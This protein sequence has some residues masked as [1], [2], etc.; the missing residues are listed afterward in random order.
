MQYLAKF[1]KN[2]ATIFQSQQN[3]KNIFDIFAIFCT[4][5][6]PESLQNLYDWAL[7]RH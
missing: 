2:V 6:V 4:M 5:L 1:D 7:R 3:I